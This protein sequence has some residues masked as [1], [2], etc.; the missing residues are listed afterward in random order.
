MNEVNIDSRIAAAF[1][2][3]EKKPEPRLKSREELLAWAYSDETVAIREVDGNTIHI[4]FKARITELPVHQ[5]RISRT[6]ALR[7]LYPRR[8][9]EG[10]VLL[11][12][13]L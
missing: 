3:I 11:R 9:H 1:G 4:H 2:K 12:R 8:R 7:I 13:Q 5:A 10:T 6:V